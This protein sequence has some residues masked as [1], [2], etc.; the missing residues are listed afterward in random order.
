MA[1]LEHNVNFIDVQVWHLWWGKGFSHEAAKQ[2]S[3][4]GSMRLFLAPQAHDHDNGAS[5][6]TW[7]IPFVA[8]SE[9]KFHRPCQLEL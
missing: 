2:R 9:Q 4:E 3:N 8:S 6:R 1:R 7:T 5:R